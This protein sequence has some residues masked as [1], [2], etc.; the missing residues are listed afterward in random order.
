M[1]IFLRCLEG[2]FAVRVAMEVGTWTGPLKYGCFVGDEYTR[3]IAES[4]T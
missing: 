3:G 4:T 1:I 2:E